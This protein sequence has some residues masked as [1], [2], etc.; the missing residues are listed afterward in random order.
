MV[1]EIRLPESMPVV[2][3]EPMESATYT[4]S[5]RLQAA[6]L[7]PAVKLFERVAAEIPL[8]AP[9]SPIVIADYGAATGYN[10]LLPLSTAI[11][12]LRRRTRHDHAILVTH[13]DVADNDFTALFRTVTDDPDSYLQHDTA[14][15]TSAI[16]RSFYTQILPT[17]TVNLGWSSWAIQWLSRLPAPLPDHIQVAYSSDKRARQAYAAQAATD[18]QDFLAFRGRE[19]CPGGKLVILTMALDENHEFGYRRFNEAFMTALHDLVHDGLLRHEEVRRM[20]VPVFARSEEDMRAPFQPKGRF[21]GLVIEQLEVFNAEDRFWT[22]FQKDGDAENF[23]AQ[24]AA[25]ARA[26]IFPSLRVGLDGG[27]NDPRGSEFIQQLEAALAERLARSPE[28]TQI[29][30][31]SLVLVKQRTG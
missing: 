18:W 20:A 16:G 2:R 23:G 4:A 10:S 8:P 29:P 22:R 9:P 11:Q 31:A 12:V 27:V 5:S 15:F 7:L 28:P 17:K 19:L 6:G 3:P 24:W 26:A 14:T 25:F 13:T 1:S 30:L 21:E